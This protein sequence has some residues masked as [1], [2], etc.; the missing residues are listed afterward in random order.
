MG[1]FQNERD[2]SMTN[3]KAAHVPVS[4]EKDRYSTS[5]ANFNYWRGYIRL[6]VKILPR[7]NRVGNTYLLPFFSFKV[8]TL[9]GVLRPADERKLTQMESETENAYWLI[10]L[11]VDPRCYLNLLL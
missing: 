9:L 10:Q 8:W 2:Q 3:S 6:L 5:T 4:K 1:Y 11:E 7:Q